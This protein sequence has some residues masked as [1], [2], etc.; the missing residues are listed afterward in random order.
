[1]KL[2]DVDIWFVVTANGDTIGRFFSENEAQ[3]FVETSR[4]HRGPMPA[5]RLQIIRRK[6]TEERQQPLPMPA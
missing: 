6:F 3:S 1:M 2:P 4:P 5:D